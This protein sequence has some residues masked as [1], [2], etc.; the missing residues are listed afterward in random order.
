MS[1]FT[2]LVL[3]QVSAISREAL[4]IS[5]HLY[6][7]RPSSITETRQMIHKLAISN[8][9]ENTLSM[10]MLKMDK[11]IIHMKY[12]GLFN[13]ISKKINFGVLKDAKDP[14]LT[15]N[16]V[17]KSENQKKQAR[18]AFM[19]TREQKVILSKT[20]G[21]PEDEI[22]RLKPLEA[23]IIIE[24]SI[25]H[26][27]M[28]WKSRV[29]TL[30]EQNEQMLQDQQ[31]QNVEENMHLKEEQSKRDTQISEL[32]MGFSEPP[33]PTQNDEKKVAD[34]NTNQ[35]NQLVL[36]PSSNKDESL[37]SP[38]LESST[39]DP[40]DE[41][42][43]SGWFAVQQHFPNDNNTQTIALYKTEEEALQCIDI[44][45]ALLSRQSSTESKSDDKVYSIKKL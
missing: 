41:K 3:Q 33:I 13:Y 38:I 16:L 18:I 29:S 31:M 39:H 14:T 32:G 11:E 20:L 4:V 9:P 37:Q 26:N 19:I 30:V 34:D 5:R 44:K 27:G 6:Q 35:G 15:R 17:T 22:R 2:K 28:D 36:V 10:T 8:A 23:M 42:R 43:I 21:Y 1:S 12:H 45:N 40:N 24:H 7:T 25:E